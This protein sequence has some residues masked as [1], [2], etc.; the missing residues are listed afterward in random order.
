MEANLNRTESS[1][2][3]IQSGIQNNETVRNFTQKISSG[4]N[5]FGSRSR[6]L[7]QQAQSTIRQY[8]MAFVV[9]GFV[10]GF[11]TARIAKRVA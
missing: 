8:P 7:S 2:V 5:R 3:G 1:G 10:V 11:I 4:L 9:G 6:D